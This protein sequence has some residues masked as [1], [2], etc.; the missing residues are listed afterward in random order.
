MLPQDVHLHMCAMCP[1]DIRSVIRIENE[2]EQES[3]V[4]VFWE[5]CVE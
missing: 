2:A 1:V 3:G 5:L 4:P